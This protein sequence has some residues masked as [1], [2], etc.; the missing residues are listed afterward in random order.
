MSVALW[1]DIDAP[2]AALKAAKAA[3]VSD[4]RTNDRRDQNLPKISSSPLSQNTAPSAL[5]RPF[6]A[7][8][9]R[10]SGGQL[11]TGA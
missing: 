3:A 2:R 9:C 11:A 4:S 1:C 7:P 10:R 5:Q 6:K 8:L